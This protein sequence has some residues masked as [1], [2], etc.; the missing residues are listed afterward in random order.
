MLIDLYSHSLPFRENLVKISNVPARVAVRSVF[1]DALLAHAKPVTVNVAQVQHILSQP[2]F[3]P[4]AMRQAMQTL[5]VEWKNALFAPASGNNIGVPASAT[6]DTT[7][8]MAGPA[9]HS[10]DESES[11]NPPTRENYKGALSQ[12]SQ[13]GTQLQPR[14]SSLSSSSSDDTSASSSTVERRV[15]ISSGS[16]SSEN[17]S[18]VDDTIEA[19][20]EP[21]SPWVDDDEEENEEVSGPENDLGIAP[22]QV[23]SSSFAQRSSPRAGEHQ[24]PETTAKPSLRFRWDKDQISF[25]NRLVAKH[26]A[27][28][29]RD[30]IDWQRI[31][32]ALPLNI[33]THQTVKQV[34]TCYYNNSYFDMTLS[35]KPRLAKRGRGPCVDD[36]DDD[37]DEEEEEEVSGSENDLGIPP[38]Q[39]SVSGFAP[40][41]SPRADGYQQ[42]E[43]TS[44]PSS[45]FRWDKEQISFLNRLV[46]KHRAGAPQDAIDWQRI[47][48]DLPSNI[49]MHQTVKQVETCF[50][51][52]CYFDMTSSPKP[53]PGLLKRG[54]WTRNEEEAIRQGIATYGFGNWA[55]I[56]HQYPSQLKD[57]T[58][59]QISRKGST[60]RRDSH[61]CLPAIPLPSG[62]RLYD[63]ADSSTDDN[64]V[65]QPRRRF[66]GDFED[67]SSSESS[68][69]SF[70]FSTQVGVPFRT[71]FHSE[72]VSLTNQPYSDC[73]RG[74][75]VL[76]RTGPEGATGPMNRRFRWTPEQIQRLKQLAVKDRSGWI[77]W[78]KVHESLPESLR[79]QQT[80]SQIKTV[81]FNHN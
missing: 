21:D 15:P 19:A 42:P 63:D 47:Y 50:Y 38:R 53:K 46:A 62:H 48:N 17:V 58:V 65:V 2:P 70:T 64:A 80:V 8:D 37:D 3:C 45:R 16:D 22:G 69:D 56:R 35:P 27:S 52:H 24:R 78:K 25:L 81:Y 43:T 9:D 54:R 28:A 59:D 1:Y 33:T 49:T 61:S 76:S 23:S 13:R 10:D 71:C 26:R 55:L 29:P 30:A 31:Y 66:A 77:D 72:N 34:E 12:W 44:K 6:E 4:A 7:W 5:L 67:D 68:D 51:N 32:K 41:R 57:R 36:D 39:V 14:R 18:I 20:A 11:T 73:E 75:G 60:M 40:G 79:N 74:Q